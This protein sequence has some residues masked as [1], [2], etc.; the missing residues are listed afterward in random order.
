MDSTKSSITLGWVKPVYDGGSAITSYVVEMREA[1]EE[2]WTVITSKGEVRTT[3]YVVYHLTHGVNYY[4]RVCAVNIAGQG[5]PIEMVE[6][7][8][9][10]DILGKSMIC[11]MP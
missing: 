8:Q 7:A 9:A 4:F 2:Q 6:P 1:D 11:R 3:E 5:E 10:K